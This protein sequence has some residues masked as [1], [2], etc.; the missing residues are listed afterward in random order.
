MGAGVG[1]VTILNGPGVSVNGATIDLQLPTLTVN[2]SPTTGVNLVNVSDGTIPAVFS[3]GSAGTPGSIANV[4]GTDFNVDGGNATITYSG[5]ITNTAGRSVAVQNRTGD[6]V[7]FNTGTI[8]DTGTGVLVNANAAGAVTD[9]LGT[10][11]LSTGAN[12]AFAATSGGT[13]RVMGAA[14]TITTTNGVALNVTSTTIG[15]GSGAPETGLRFRSISAGTA[16]SG[17][18]NGIVLNTTGAL[19]GLTV[20][21]NGGAGTGGTIQ[22]TTG[23]GILLTSTQG[24]TLSSMNITTVGDDGING[25]SVNGLTMTGCNVTNAGNSATDEGIELNNPTGTLT[26]TNTAVTGSAHN[27]V[28]IDANNVNLTA[29]NVTGCTFSNNKTSGVG[30]NGFLL[31]VRG[32]STLGTSTIN[33]TAFSDTVVS[34]LKVDAGDTATVSSFTVQN[35]TFS[36]I[37][38]N[39]IDFTQAQGANA[40]YRVL[41]NVTITGHQSHAVNVFSSA[42]ATGGSIQARIQGNTIGNAGSAGSGSATGSGI[43]VFIQG[44]T[45]GTVLIDGNMIRQTPQSRGIDVQFLGPTAAGPAAPVNDVTVT[46]NDVNPQDSTGFPVSAIYVAADSQGGATV[47]VRSDVRGNTVPAGAAFDVLPTYLAVDEVVAAAVCQVVDTPPASANPTAQLTSTNTGSA[48]AAAGCAL[49]AGPINTP[50]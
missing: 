4:T 45:A 22:R 13:L 20:T 47:T 19:G 40:V 49:I 6:S 3:A 16:A 32:T 42:S 34:Q 15:A 27:H 7:T 21:G 41:N 31:S 46:N 14:N 48:S 50:L 28:K 9:F 36:G 35:S 37:S 25:T 24:V 33:T 43:R 18:A 8:N 26:F 5:S 38:G 12:A 44:R 23:S 2:S 17:P 1:I 29:I 39:A 11:T 10:L 30:A